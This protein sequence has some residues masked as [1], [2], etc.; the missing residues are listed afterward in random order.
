MKIIGTTEISFEIE[1]ILNKAE[2][3][4]VLVTPYLKLNQRIKV[5]LSDAFKRVDNIYILHREKELNY[6]EANWLK[7]FDNIKIFPIKNLHSKI[8]LNEDSLLI[9]SMNLYEYSQVNNHEIGVKMN[10]SDDTKEYNDTLNEIRII[11]ESQYASSTHNFEEILE[12]TENYSMSRL[13]RELNDKYSFRNFKKGSQSL[14]EY[15]SDKSRVLVEF[16]E[17]EL[18][19]D[20]T[21]VLRSTE[22]GKERYQILGKELK[23]LSN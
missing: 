16:D 9:S 6:N 5:R 20:K 13:F 11:L 12:T 1:K 2:K 7:S 22:L 10:Y 21:A 15:I 4:L 3:F 14:Y 17:S 8:Y 18:Y 23:K 19:Q